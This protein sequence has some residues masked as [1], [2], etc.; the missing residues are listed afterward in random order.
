M[1]ELSFRKSKWSFQVLSQSL[2]LFFFLD[3]SQ[4]LKYQYYILSEKSS[5][6]N[7]LNN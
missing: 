2:S 6:K 1:R 7:F 4:D 3:S 5:V